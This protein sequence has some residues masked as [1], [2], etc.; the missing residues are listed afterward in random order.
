VIDDLTSG[1]YEIPNLDA[2]DLRAARRLVARHQDL[3]IGLTD[4]VNAVPPP[5]EPV[6]QAVARCCS[7]GDPGAPG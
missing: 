6:E 4:A 1:A 2:D 7:T 3:K 5:A